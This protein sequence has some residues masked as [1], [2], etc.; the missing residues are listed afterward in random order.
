MVVLAKRNAMIGLRAAKVLSACALGLSTHNALAQNPNSFIPIS[1]SDGGQLAYSQATGLVYG[2]AYNNTAAGGIVYSVDPN[3][4]GATPQTVFS[5]SSLG[6]GNYGSPIGGVTVDVQGNIFGTEAGYTNGVTSS[7]GSVYELKN[8]GGGSYTFINLN[9]LPVSGNGAW[10]GTTGAPVFD[11]YGNL[12]ISSTVGGA[13]NQGSLIE[14]SHIYSGTPTTTDLYDFGT[15]PGDGQFL[16]GNL[17]VTNNSSGSVTLYAV[18]SQNGANGTG[19]GIYSLTVDPNNPVQQASINVVHSASFSDGGD[20]YNG[21]VVVYASGNLYGSTAYSFTTGGTTLYKISA[22]GQYST[23]YTAPGFS[24]PT[25][26]DYFVGT[27]LLIDNELIGMARFGGANGGGGMYDYNLLTGQMTTRINFGTPGSDLITG[28]NPESI[29]SMLAIDTNQGLAYLGTTS[30]DG[31]NG[32][33][34]I[35]VITP[36]PGSLAFAISGASVLGGIALRR[37]RRQPAR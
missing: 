31:P 7:A 11:K 30:M 14:I 26:I 4:K 2:S 28:T 36:E 27:P 5:F 23:L 8:N 37:R 15:Q 24:D 18:A 3:A 19:T 16:L 6:A 1:F 21:G 33:G 32:W 9:T 29:E 17:A 12:Y 25:A 13:Y 10:N 22:A 20:D 34:T 35:V